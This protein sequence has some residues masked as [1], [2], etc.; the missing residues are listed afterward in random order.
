MAYYWVTEAQKYIQSLGFGSTRRAID[1]GPQP[2]RI[3]QS[4]PDNSFA[5]DHPRTRSASA[6]AGWTTPRTPR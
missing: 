1:N 4:G 6:R 3:N 5:T 2:V